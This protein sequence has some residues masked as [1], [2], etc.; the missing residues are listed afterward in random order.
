[1]VK[2][3]PNCSKG[4]EETSAECPYC[5][6]IFSKWASKPN[7]DEILTASPIYQHQSQSVKMSWVLAAG[8]IVL[9]FVGLNKVV[10]EKTK[11]FHSKDAGKM[12]NRLALK[13][14]GMDSPHHFLNFIQDGDVDA[15]RK[16]LDAGYSPDTR[17]PQGVPLELAIMKG[18]KEMLD[19]FIQSGADVNAKDRDGRSMAA[20]ALGRPQ[21]I[22]EKGMASDQM[23]KILVAAGAKFA[24]TESDMATRALDQAVRQQ[25]ADLAALLRQAGA[26]E[27]SAST[28]AALDL[29]HKLQEEGYDVNGPT[30]RDLL[31]RGPEYSMPILLGLVNASVPSIGYFTAKMLPLFSL[32]NPQSVPLL[33]K[34]IETGDYQIYTYAGNLLTKIGPPAIFPLEPLLS[35]DSFAIRMAAVGILGNIGDPARPL[36]PKLIDMSEKDNHQSVRSKAKWAADRIQGLVK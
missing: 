21:W 2:P 27:P 26:S 23:F 32:Q 19:L 31:A 12:A 29:A 4:V 5:S 34:C 30:A 25:N 17:G 11:G 15:V 13:A 10:K 16:Y 7:Q 1:M 8:A 14:S 24:P 18:Q 9:L 20:L 33:I 6:I 36:L 28:S 35:N 22:A 3:C